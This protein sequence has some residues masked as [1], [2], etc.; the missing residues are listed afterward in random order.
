MSTTGKQEGQNAPAYTDA[1]GATED[2][3]RAL[4]TLLYEMENGKRDPEEIKKEVEAA[5][6]AYG[7]AVDY[8]QG[9]DDVDTAREICQVMGIT[10]KTPAGS[11]VV[12]FLQE[13]AR[14][15][16]TAEHRGDPRPRRYGSCYGG[17]IKAI[18]R[19]YNWLYRKHPGVLT[20]EARKPKKGELAPELQEPGAKRI[21]DAAVKA[22]ILN[23]DYSPS[24]KLKTKTLRAYFAKKFSEAVGWKDAFGKPQPKYAPFGRLWNENGYGNLMRVKGYNSKGVQG[25]NM[26][27]KFFSN[28]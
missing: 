25:G 8:L 20:G 18:G 4:E 23:G 27:D 14:V 13:K 22:G 19:L 28:L 26:V 1:Y 12:E 2:T 3:I 10:D 24:D 9:T 17:I 7:R 5:G 6:E 21:L 11:R 15:L 16:S